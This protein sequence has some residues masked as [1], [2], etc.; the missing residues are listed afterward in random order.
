MNG[1]PRYER[2]KGLK[3]LGILA[4][5]AGLF[6]L[7][8]CHLDSEE[9]EAHFDLK[10]DSSWASCDSLIVILEDT[11]GVAIDTL[12]NDTLKSLSQLSHLSAAKYKGGMAQVRILGRKQG[13]V[14][15]E[16]TRTFDDR[17]GPVLVDTVSLP[18]SKPSSIQLR[19][20]TLEISVGDPSA[21]I[22][23]TISPS[24]ADQVFE[25]SVEDASIATLDFP[26][27]PNSGK[28]MVI[29]QKNGTVKI[30]VR[31]KQD[32]SKSAV[33]LVKVGSVSG[34]S[35]SLSPDTLDLYLGGPDSA[36]A[37]KVSPEESDPDISWS[38]S[39]EKIAKVDGKGAV[40]AIGEGS[41]RI[42]AKFGDAAATAE[43]R[44]KKDAPVL[45]V[46]SK[47]GAGVNVPITFTP[48]ATQKFGSIVMF[49]WDLN[50]D[51]DWDDSLSGPFL[52]TTVDLPAQTARFSKEGKNT[53]RFLV[54]DS[55]GN[56]TEASVDLDIG[57][58]PPEI[59]S[60]SNDTV[61]SIKDS[62]PLRAKVHD[63]EGKVAWIGW[64]FENDGKF[65]DTSETG[66][67]TVEI[68]SGHRYDKAGE[69]AAVLRAVD[70][71]G[72]VR[73]DSVIV[74]VKTDAPIADAGND[75]TV[76]AGTKVNF[77]A[78]GTDSLGTIAKRELK[79]GDGPFI[80]LGK[81]DTSFILPNES[82][83]VTCVVRVTDDDGNSDEDEMVVTIV[84][85][86][87][88]NNNLAGL[89]P[90][91]GALAPVFKPVTI[92]YSM[93]V[94]YADSQVSVTAS[95]FDPQ[96]TLAINGKPASSGTP[97][98][99]VDVK[100]G[101]TID[102]FKVVVT[103]QDGNQKVYSVS[104]TR[105]PST[106]ASLSKLE[107]DGFSLKPAFSSA[108]L[109]YAD[110]VAFS[111]GSV[112][113]KPATAHPAAKVQVNDT[114]VASGDASKALSLV[115][116][117]NLIKV[118]V[119][120]Q[121]GKTK[122]T[123]NVKVVRRAKL[124]LSRQ[125]GGGATTSSDS[126]EYPLGTTVSI[127]SPDTVGY[128]FQKWVVTEG[129]A[130]V[131]D[132]TAN[133]AN[134][135]LKSNVVRMLGVQV[136]NAYKISTSVSGA[137][138]GVFSPASCTVQHGKDTS[139]T[140]TPLVGYR[141]LKLTDNG[142]EVSTLGSAGGFGVRTFN[143]T[144]VTEKHDLVA[145]F[146]KTYTLTASVS[147]SGTITPL[148][149]IE[150]DSGSSQ[151]YT[152]V[153]GSPST[154]VW[155]SAF[156]DNGADQTGA[157]TDDR[158]NTSHYALKNI[159]ENHTIVATFAV[160]TFTMKVSGHDLCIRKVVT[161]TG[162]PR[163]CLT[164]LCLV[165]SGPDA[166]TLTVSYGDSYTLGTAD[167]VAAGRPFLSWSKDG[168]AISGS[169]TTLTT[170]P[171][172]ADVT[173]SASYKL[174][175]IKCCPGVCCTIIDPPILTPIGSVAEPP[176]ASSATLPQSKDPPQEN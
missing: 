42:K 136:L 91:A 169:T 49:K 87:K 53:V 145:T 69:F 128:H 32:T 93:S 29:P 174:P 129:T 139:L 48:K 62:I 58:Q 147:G 118:V 170:G 50:G 175:I 73:L 84:A 10:A 123:Y 57:N 150:V 86:D 143:L 51:K 107:P 36:F 171:I 120:A 110:T 89:A 108:V 159:T 80:N 152:M 19:T 146:L 61:I 64:D 66:D 156:T 126:L 102:V 117:D 22:L 125:L 157:I 12:F 44:V 153:S 109:D 30:L 75:T 46:N 34:K 166:D 56:E 3:A 7:W 140:I 18:G 65:D 72:K 94:A 85:P 54:R 90:S 37:A 28:V 24:F 8:A 122:S 103:A 148:G 92:I 82:G 158:M 141:L 25:W 168:T 2:L 67:S 172:T 151:G 176:A 173:Y 16:Q 98:D 132:T 38:S 60:I 15:A 119:T 138:G 111:V 164:K 104:V 149:A 23:A 63:L 95:T 55:E 160:K 79:V 101:T 13:G 96:A 130:T 113:L 45:T 106:D 41:A 21:E 40:T 81:Q 83:T 165:G 131:E 114:D 47:T 1:S 88:S 121:D 68:K 144:K 99:P 161:C 135:T 71:N 5:L 9:G 133:P 39:D 14:C 52:G 97:S 43:V 77:H 105:A 163:L 20:S 31:A 4:T 142:K 59:V 115:V 78:K 137:A 154:G 116:G 11:D 127:T 17:G 134:V 74:K 100:V 167:S 33:L 6:I 70:E 112:K 26:K 76:I 155:V 35:I 27:G 162:D 124:I